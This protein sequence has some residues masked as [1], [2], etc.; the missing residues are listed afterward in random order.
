M[1]PGGVYRESGVGRAES[2]AACESK[3]EAP[4]ATSRG[5]ADGLHVSA[6][7]PSS[8]RGYTLIEVIVAFALLALALTLLLGSLSSA[9]RQVHWADGA[10]RATLYAQSLLD[11][12][13]VGAP[14]S[15]GSRSGDFEDGRYHWTLDVHPYV[16]AGAIKPATTA[17][18]AQLF[19]IGLQIE[20]GPQAA[21]HLQMQTLRLSRTDSVPS[22]PTP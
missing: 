13:G 1:M 22:A 17:D 19:E 21:Q 15:A 10:G 8:M 6:A 5:R 9:A 16:E 14:L 2:V 12:A 11:Q 20:W 18:G 4:L 3:A 7:R